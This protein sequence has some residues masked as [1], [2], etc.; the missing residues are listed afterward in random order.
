MAGRYDSSPF[1]EGEL[2]CVFQLPRDDTLQP[3]CKGLLQDAGE[4]SLAASLTRIEEEQCCFL[5]W[6]WNTGPALYPYKCTVGGWHGRFPNQ[7]VHICFV[8]L[9][10]PCHLNVSCGR[11]SA[12]WC[13]FPF[14]M[15]HTISV[16]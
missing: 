16:L 5:S 9:E 2:E 15:G 3:H 4:E 14:V 1:E 12:V 10:K 11:C 8:D 7:P 6:L 13:R